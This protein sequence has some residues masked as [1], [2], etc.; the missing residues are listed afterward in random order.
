MPLFPPIQKLAPLLVV[1]IGVYFYRM[2][3]PSKE[4]IVL[5]GTISFGTGL[6][7][8]TFRQQYKLSCQWLLRRPLVVRIRARSTG[9]VHRVLSDGRASTRA[10]LVGPGA[11]LHEL[12]QLS[13]PLFDC[14]SCPGVYIF[15]SRMIG[16]L[17]RDPGLVHVPNHQHDGAFRYVPGAVGGARL[18]IPRPYDLL[19]NQRRSAT[20]IRHAQFGRWN[21]GKDEFKL[22]SRM[23]PKWLKNH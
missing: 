5:L 13:V 10:I 23:L 8:R 17:G 14:R 6:S 15:L 3:P 16:F 7:C 19:R 9:N 1:I 4:A 12:V 18:D 2:Q 22:R 21:T 11:S 20:R